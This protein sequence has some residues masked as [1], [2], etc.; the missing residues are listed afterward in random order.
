MNNIP[1]EL[2]PLKQWVVVKITPQEIA[3]KTH[4]RPIVGTSTD[5][6]TWMDAET[7]N[8]IV[9]SYKAE[10]TE[11]TTQY[12]LG[13][14]FTDANDICGIDLDLP[15][16]PTAD[17]PEDYHTFYNSAK[18]QINTLISDHEQG[19]PETYIDQSISGRGYHIIMKSHVRQLAFKSATVEFYDTGRYF[20]FSGGNSNGLLIQDCTAKLDDYLTILRSLR[21]ERTKVDVHWTEEDCELS[22]GEL[23]VEVLKHH[24]DKSS[25]KKMLAGPVD[26]SI[27]LNK[28]GTPRGYSESTMALMNAMSAETGITDSNLMLNT[29]F[30]SAWFT[31]PMFRE[32]Y[33]NSR[34]QHKL[35]P[36][37][38]YNW[39]MG[40]MID[41]IGWGIQ[42]R[43]QKELASGFGAE[44]AANFLNQASPT[45][46]LNQQK[47]EYESEDYQAQLASVV[48]IEEASESEESIVY[49]NALVL[50]PPGQLLKEIMAFNMKAS[51]MPNPPVCLASALHLLASWTG[52]RYQT[53]TLQGLTFYGLL[54]GASRIGKSD[55]KTA[56][57][58]LFKALRDND[59]SADAFI[60]NHQI[61][62]KAGSGVGLM[63]MLNS[64]YERNF[65]TLSVGRIEN[66]VGEI[67]GAAKKQGSA[68]RDVLTV[69]LQAYDTSGMYKSLDG[70]GYSDN[71]KDMESM[72]AANFTFLGEG[73]PESVF[74]GLTEKDV[75]SGLLPRFFFFA[76]GD[77]EPEMNFTQA[78]PDEA[79]KTLLNLCSEL[80]NKVT[81]LEQGS[82]FYQLPFEPEAGKW[83][84]N[85][86]IP[87]TR[88]RRNNLDRTSNKRVL[89]G[90]FNLMILRLAS[91]AAISKNI[92]NPVIDM[93]CLLWGEAFLEQS[94]EV[95]VTTMGNE[96]DV[97]SLKRERV[98][99]TKIVQYLDPSNVKSGVDLDGRRT[100]TIG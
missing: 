64:T 80:M 67:F 87:S 71:E 89:L 59:V 68:T 15:P 57:E 79:P 54:F 74:E 41:A 66:E 70:M 35:D 12:A 7:A 99:A 97:V 50:N 98:V 10:E 17:D 40:Q 31:S 25:I 39:W 46:I 82:E 60:S 91:L 78:R 96:L 48:E 77:K 2:Q 37:R 81:E 13:F 61:K 52:S 29:F 62:K 95:I 56:Q 84:Q 55:A 26:A 85:S 90:G 1:A 93:E 9:Q 43:Q 36:N 14:C 73:T 100:P 33:S 63:R 92:H 34:N 49:S 76:C 86:Y 45:E 8:K 21:A 75:H 20:V 83:Y 27:L 6:T 19:F 65:Q 51:I 18:L 53:P 11:P 5:E 22:P 30:Q 42:K 72:D 28:D 69:L 44:V 94:L 32:H 58:V 24:T 38:T 47:S 3:G 88:K 23:I 16:E 4:K